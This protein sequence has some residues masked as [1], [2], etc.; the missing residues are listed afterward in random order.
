MGATPERLLREPKTLGNLIE[1]LVIRDLRIYSAPYRGNVYHYRD[2]ENREIDA[3]IEY[4]D[5][6]VAV[7][8]KLGVGAVE[9]AAD[10]LKTIISRIDTQTM[11]EPDAILIIVGTGPGYTRP[12]GISVVP[13]GA[14]RP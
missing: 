6:W 4:P 2:S 7:E 1:S 3:I 10:K 14:L 12:D 9:E 8:V 13:I 11:G 5:G